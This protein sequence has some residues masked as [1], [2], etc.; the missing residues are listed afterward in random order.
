MNDEEEPLSDNDQVKVGTNEDSPSD[1]S[2]SSDSPSDDTE[3]DPTFSP[4]QG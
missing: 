3:L 1:S 4:S 2:D